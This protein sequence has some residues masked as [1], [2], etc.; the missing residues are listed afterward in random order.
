MKFTAKEISR[1]RE[2]TKRGIA[3]TCTAERNGEK[4]EITAH[5]LDALKRFVKLHEDGIAIG[6]SNIKTDTMT[7]IYG[8]ECWEF[9][10]IA[11]KNIM[12]PRKHGI[13]ADIGALRDLGRKLRIKPEKLDG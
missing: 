4:A 9:P 7:F 13:E 3:L 10:T 2:M 1:A 8:D 6:W 12:R 11:V 5:G